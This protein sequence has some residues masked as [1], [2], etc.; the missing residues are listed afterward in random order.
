MTDKPRD[1][2]DGNAMEALPPDSDE[3]VRRLRALEWPAVQ[4]DVAER[5]W[6]EFSRR[7]DADGG[8]GNGAAR[9]N[10]GRRHDM[11]RYALPR[12][13]A[14]AAYSRTPALRARSAVRALAR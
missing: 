8:D 9:R 6:N 7:L 4:P 11:T 3:L 12:A 10:V 13:P 1:E 5:C 2:S 14:H